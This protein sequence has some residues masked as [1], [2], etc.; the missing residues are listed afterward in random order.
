MSSRC[1]F[2]CV[3]TFCGSGVARFG[4][5]SATKVS[6]PALGEGLGTLS[7]EWR[8]EAM[9]TFCCDCVFSVCEVL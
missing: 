3:L 6:M 2:Q 7:V 5:V 1:V 9:L 8:S 4:R